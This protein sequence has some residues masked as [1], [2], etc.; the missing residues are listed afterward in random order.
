[1]VRYYEKH[2][3]KELADRQL[4]AIIK[5]YDEDTISESDFVEDFI[6]EEE[7]ERLIKPKSK[8]DKKLH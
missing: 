1:M 8:K 2:N 6:E 3:T 7:E 5:S 4:E